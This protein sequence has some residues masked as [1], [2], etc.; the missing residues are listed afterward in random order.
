VLTKGYP[1]PQAT[2]TKD[3]LPIR[4]SSGRYAVSPSGSLIIKDVR[5]SD[6]GHYSIIANHFYMKSNP[7]LYSS[8]AGSSYSADI[9]VGVIKGEESIRID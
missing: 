6:K 1:K 9:I 5:L 4:L 2:W 7:G 3:N 8:M